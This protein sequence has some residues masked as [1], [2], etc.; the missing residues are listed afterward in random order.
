[1]YREDKYNQANAYCS[2]EFCSMAYSENTPFLVMLGS[3]R[4]TKLDLNT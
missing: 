2:L 4:F 3:S 1:M